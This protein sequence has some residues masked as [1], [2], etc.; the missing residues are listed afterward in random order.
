M[1]VSDLTPAELAYA[2]RVRRDIEAN[3]AAR[4][5]A[6]T[7][8]ATPT[9][10]P[11]R[12]ALPAPRT[13]VVVRSGKVPLLGTLGGLLMQVLLMIGVNW[14]AGKTAGPP[15]EMQ[16]LDDTLTQLQKLKTIAEIMRPATSDTPGAVKEKPATA[17][18]IASDAVN[19]PVSLFG[20]AAVGFVTVFVVSQARAGFHE[21]TETTKDL[22]GEGRRA[23]G[24][25]SRAD[26]STRNI[27]RRAKS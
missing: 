15:P 1:A 16:G 27:S 26:A 11:S 20:I 19:K 7:T 2:E 14:F 23:A 9:T 12:V 18:Q 6:S 17:A 10:T 3:K 24:S 8:T 21:V 25:L 22:Y 5:A 13:P 4:M